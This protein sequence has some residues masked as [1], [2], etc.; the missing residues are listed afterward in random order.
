M[1]Y[2]TYQE[3]V[4][5]TLQ[6]G[7]IGKDGWVLASDRVRIDTEG[8]RVRSHIQ[9]IFM[10]ES[11]GLSYSFYG[12]D[13]AIIT[14]DRL[15]ENSDK[16]NELANETRFA[17][18]AMGTG[19]QLVAVDKQFDAERAQRRVSRY[20]LISRSADLF[21]KFTKSILVD[22][23]RSAFSCYISNEQASSRRRR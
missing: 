13:L 8:I 14:G 5:V 16:L 22:A 11:E 17:P 10:L 6:V 12:D 21:E 19:K 18:M 3:E 15:Q 4:P 9:K 7:M 1:I 2:C 23:N 20:L